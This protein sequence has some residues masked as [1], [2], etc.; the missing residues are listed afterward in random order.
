MHATEWMLGGRTVWIGF[1]LSYL[2][3]LRTSVLT[4]ENGGEFHEVYCLK[5]S[6][7][8]LELTTSCQGL[9]KEK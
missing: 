6:D 7:A 9:K 4:A 1:A 8:A 5:R 3:R 2:F